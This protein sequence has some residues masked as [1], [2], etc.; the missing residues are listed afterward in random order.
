MINNTTLQKIKNIEVCE[1]IDEYVYDIEIDSDDI[2]E[3]SFF[4]NDILLHNS[5][6]CSFEEVI[7]NV[8]WK[9]SGKDLVLNIYKYRLK[10]Y[11]EDLF[12]KYVD[13]FN[14][15]GYYLDFELETISTIGLFVAKKKY[16]QSLSWK[17]RVNYDDY[18]KIKVTGIEI[19]QR[20][21]PIFCR[22][23]LKELVK[24]VLKMG[25]LS[26]EDGTFTKMMNKLQELKTA[27]KKSD[28]ELICK[29]AKINKYEKFVVDDT[30]NL[31]I[32][33]K[34]PVHIKAAATYNYMLNKNNLK[35]RYNLIKNGDTVKWYYTKDNQN[36]VFCFLS[37]YMPSFAPQ[38]NYKEMFEKTVL[39]VVNRVVNAILKDTELDYS[40]SY[41]DNLF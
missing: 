30:N 2:N 26:F 38:F 25:G 33:S 34:C 15:M 18:S 10:K 12:K 27:H 21:T 36:P 5:N 9:G 7:E 16:I 32:R 24:D 14:G 35:H 28:I 17:D 19:V 37:G 6:Y 22:Q 40:L 20:S 13:D 39:G 11:F 29:N 3:Q 31:E 1:Y 23:V 4:G 8:G 41:D